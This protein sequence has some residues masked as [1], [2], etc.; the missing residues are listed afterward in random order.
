[1]SVRSIIFTVA[2]VAAAFT[3]TLTAVSPAMAATAGVEVSYSDLNLDTSLG[4]QALDGRIAYAARKLCGDYSHLELRFFADSRA[5]QQEVI[6][7]AQAQRE[8][9]LGGDRFASLIVRRAAS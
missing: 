7:G 9:V 5:C 3:S 8:A 6:A 1:M 2:A 4:R